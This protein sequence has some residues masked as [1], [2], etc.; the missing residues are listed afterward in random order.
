METTSSSKSVEEG[1]YDEFGT[2]SSSS[3]KADDFEHAQR[4]LT[5]EWKE[6]FP[7][8]NYDFEKSSAKTQTQE[9]I[10]QIKAEFKKEMKDQFEEQVRLIE[11]RLSNFKSHL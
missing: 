1:S 8:H 2:E 6:L 10:E 11:H 7:D 5:P 3:H 9:G 4:W